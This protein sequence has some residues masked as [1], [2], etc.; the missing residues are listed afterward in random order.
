MALFAAATE[1]MTFTGPGVP[2]TPLPGTTGLL[3]GPFA[4]Q[5]QVPSLQL[6]IDD[7]FTVPRGMREDRRSNE[8]GE[9]VDRLEEPVP[10]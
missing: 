3:D 1:G 4:P 7:S 10:G 6:M 5:L 8:N 2:P 9:E